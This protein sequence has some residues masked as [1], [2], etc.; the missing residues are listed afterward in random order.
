[1]ALRSSPA[2][3]PS[4]CLRIISASPS[5]AL[6]PILAT[7]A[8]YARRLISARLLPAAVE[9]VQHPRTH[10]KNPLE[11][12]NYT[13]ITLIGFG[14]AG[15]LLLSHILDI[16]P[17]HKITIVDPDF[18][19]GDLARDY[20]AIDTNTTISQKVAA[21]LSIQNG[22]WSDTAIALNA[23]GSSSD[24]VSIASLAED[25][26][27]TGHRL[28][29]AC[30][31]IYDEVDNAVWDD[32]KKTWTLTFKTKK[33]SHTTSIIC[34]CT[35]MVPRQD[36]YGIPIIPLRIALDPTALAKILDPGQEVVIV[37]SAHSATL[38]MKHLNAI[39]DVRA[40]CL[41]RGGEPFKYARDGNYGGI[42]QESASIA[43]AI[44]RDEYSRLSFVPI[45]DICGLSSTLRR[46]N[47]I[48]QAT[49]FNSR[50]VRFTTDKN[51]QPTWDP[52]TGLAPELPQ[53]QAFG[54]CVPNISIIEGKKYPDISVGS[55]IDQLLVR[56]PLLQTQINQVI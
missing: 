16:I 54:A 21:F 6:A 10:S 43:D 45:T 40:T 5:A 51:L 42:K 9:T 50:M 14:V 12:M 41:Y 47:W 7:A 30:H 29:A 35:G 22:K 18:I 44:I 27:K 38:I 31:Q 3:I 13:P 8:A 23:R 28:A 39:P 24:C 2:L 55:F 1:M 15:Q 19:G 49:G 4:S 37:G 11:Q 53:V 36:D 46:A 26:R 34:V 32:V 56:W 33:P 25:I 48:I 52:A 20:S 17:E